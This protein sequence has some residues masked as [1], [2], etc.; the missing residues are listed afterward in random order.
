MSLCKTTNMQHCKP[1]FLMCVLMTFYFQLNWKFIILVCFAYIFENIYTLH[2]LSP[3]IINL[4]FCSHLFSFQT[5]LFSIWS[6]VNEELAKI[7]EIALWQKL[8]QSLAGEF[9]YK[10]SISP[11]VQKNVSL[12]L[13]SNSEDMPS[14]DIGDLHIIWYVIS[15]ESA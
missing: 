14:S 11:T 12:P 15:V 1:L 8:Y 10:N 13:T 5:V 4:S 3:M 2:L 7:W 9:L 6:I